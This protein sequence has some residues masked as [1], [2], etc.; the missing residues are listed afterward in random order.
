H[1]RK[2]VLLPGDAGQGLVGL[3]HAD[4]MTLRQGDELLRALGTRGLGMQKQPPGAIGPVEQ[5]FHGGKNSGGIGVSQFQ[6]IERQGGHGFS[7]FPVAAPA[8]AYSCLPKSAFVNSLAS[9]GWRSSMPSPTP[10]YHTG[11]FSSWR[12][13]RAMPPLAVPS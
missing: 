9:K 6:V 12:M 10:M 11:T 13:D 2:A 4:M 3:L 5:A 1:R 8:Q 7:S